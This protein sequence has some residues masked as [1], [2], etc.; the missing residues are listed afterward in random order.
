MA[1]LLL[2]RGAQVEVFDNGG[3]SPLALAVGACRFDTADL[4]IQWGADLYGEIPEVFPMVQDIYKDKIALREALNI[5]DLGAPSYPLFEGI[6]KDDYSRVRMMLLQGMNPDSPDSQGVTPLMVAASQ[7]TPYMTEL[8]V[9]QGAD[10]NVR[11]RA[12]LTPL[13]VA[14][15]FG[16]DRNAAL[17]MDGGADLNGGKPLTDS[18]LYYGLIG[19]SSSLVGELIERGCTVTRRD[20]EGRTALMYAAFLGD[21]LSVRNLLSAGARAT[22]L[23]GDEEGVVYYAMMGY[24]MSGGENYFTIIDRLI[25]EGAESRKYLSMAGGDRKF[26][27]LLEARWRN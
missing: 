20:G 26:Y 12:G 17:L 24:Q 19:G 7:E 14:L 1:R 8:L 13:A 18:P 3:L 6:L 10:P 23:D 9:D 21:W 5:L 2:E 25:G 11:D 16:R 22:A 15:Y 27:E 4:L